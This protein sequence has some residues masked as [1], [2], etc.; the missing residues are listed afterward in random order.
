M[1]LVPDASHGASCRSQN[2][3]WAFSGVPRYA[4]RGQVLKYQF[5]EAEIARKSENVFCSLQKA[6]TPHALPLVKPDIGAF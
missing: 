2:P 6:R 4:A 5:S 3:S 1:I